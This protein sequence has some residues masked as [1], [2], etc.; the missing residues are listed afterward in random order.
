MQVK[1]LLIRFFSLFALIAGTG[2][3]P[4]RDILGQEDYVIVGID[5]CMVSV[6]VGVEGGK[7]IHHMTGEPKRYV[8]WF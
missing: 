6:E 3:L 8:F 7:C 5:D 4:F 1:I 2:S